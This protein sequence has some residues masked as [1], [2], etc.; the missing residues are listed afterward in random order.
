MI[1]LNFHMV[2]L[3]CKQIIKEAHTQA[4]EVQWPTVGF[5]AAPFRVYMRGSTVSMGHVQAQ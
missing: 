1:L 5:L 3:W 2:L 4:E